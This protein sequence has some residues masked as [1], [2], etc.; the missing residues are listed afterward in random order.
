[1][2]VSAAA[3]LVVS[4]PVAVSSLIA[5]AL[6]PEGR[7]LA[8]PGGWSTVLVMFGKVVYGIVPYI[9]LAFFLT[10]LT[11]STGLGIFLAIGYIF[12]EAIII[13]FLGYRFEGDYGWFQNLLDFMLG[14]AVSGWLV[15]EGVRAAGED[16][17]FF[18][19]DKVQ[20]NLRAFLVILAYTTALSGAALRLFLRRD[21]TS[22]RSA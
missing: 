13:S 22:A 8:D 21:V 20:S 6:A 14:P 4:I 16:A 9:A 7:E 15:E 19:L 2:L 1:M 17:A 12:S 18:P 11:R 5:T 3:F 10:V